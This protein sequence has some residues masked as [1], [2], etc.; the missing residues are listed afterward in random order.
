MVKVFRAWTTRKRALAENK[1]KGRQ[2]DQ[3]ASSRS[4]PAGGFHFENRKKRI[5]TAP[6]APV[7]ANLKLRDKIM[8]DIE[9]LASKMRSGFEVRL[10]ILLF[11]FGCFLLF[12][13]VC[14]CCFKK[15]RKHNISGRGYSSL[16]VCLLVLNES[17]VGT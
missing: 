16:F 7:L 5:V 12:V 6:N 4:V 10:L 8:G 13:F 14:R 9:E 17:A 3:S 15:L 1:I 2:L 11:V